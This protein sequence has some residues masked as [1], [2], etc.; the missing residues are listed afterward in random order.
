MNPLN[1]NMDIIMF[2]TSSSFIFFGLQEKLQ[3]FYF[4]IFEFPIYSKIRNK[5]KFHGNLTSL[6]HSI[7]NSGFTIY[8][9]YNQFNIFSKDM[10][11]SITFES[12][13]ML[14][15]SL[16]Y[17]IYDTLSMQVKNFYENDKTMILHHLMTVLCMR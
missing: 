3:E 5:I 2:I 4:K 9:F 7:I 15:T 13:I 6:L 11:N 1:N 16:G 12:T 10:I 17:F 14:S 8:I